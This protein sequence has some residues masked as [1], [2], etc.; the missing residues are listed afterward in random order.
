MTRPTCDHYATQPVDGSTVANPTP[1]PGR[2]ECLRCGRTFAG[3]RVVTRVMG[4]EDRRRA[5]IVA[6]MI[7]NAGGEVDA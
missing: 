3:T 7:A 2:I 4:D 1:Q 6:T 5:E